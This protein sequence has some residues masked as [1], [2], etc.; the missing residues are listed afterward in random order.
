[1]G[2]SVNT[3]P[4]NELEGE[5]IL[6]G[7][8][9]G[10]KGLEIP[11]ILLNNEGDIIGINPECSNLLGYHIEH[12]RDNTILDIT[13]DEDRLPE[14]KNIIDIFFSQKHGSWVTKNILTQS[15]QPVRVDQNTIAFR[16]AAK[17]LEYALVT[18]TVRNSFNKKELKGKL[19]KLLS[20]AEFFDQDDFGSHY[21]QEIIRTIKSLLNE[22]HAFL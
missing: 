5:D 1:M 12:L 7:W 6:P 15:N 8:W 11:M 14:A 16:S 22:I 13:A 10:L 9:K 18:F 21:N 4:I 19:H 20:T 2:D 17:D 3:D